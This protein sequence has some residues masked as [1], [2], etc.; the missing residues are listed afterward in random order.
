[1][2]HEGCRCAPEG[3][4]DRTVRQSSRRCNGLRRLLAE[5]PR[6]DC[7]GPLLRARQTGRNGINSTQIE[8]A[9]RRSPPTRVSP[10]Q[11]SREIR[12]DGRYLERSDEEEEFAS[13]ARLT[14]LNEA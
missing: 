5:H 14:R 6:Q 12:E 4:N 1:D 13:R 2:R 10:R 11:R 7:R 8:R 3:G 9:N